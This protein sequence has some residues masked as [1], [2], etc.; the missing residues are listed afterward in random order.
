MTLQATRALVESVASG[1]RL[2]VETL[3]QQYLPGLRAFIRLRVGAE[4]R[5]KE[6]SSDI[7]QSVCRELFEGV[8]KFRWEGEAA[9]RAWL[10]T[11]ALRKLADRVEHYRAQ[12]RDVA[13]EMSPEMLRANS[14]ASVWDC[15]QTI[16]T[17]SGHAIAREQAQRIEKA[18]ESL[19]EEEREVVTLARVAGLSRAEIGQQIGKSEGAVR[20]ILHRALA[21]VAEFLQDN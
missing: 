17:P 10:Y 20:V 16:S 2:A 6:S 14:E 5:A 19:T 7:A 11:A 4:I 9:F 13:R 12:K 8:G 18:F 15:Y 1:D 21:Q 3:L